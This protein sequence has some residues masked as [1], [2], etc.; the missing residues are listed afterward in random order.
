MK[1]PSH[2]H[3]PMTPGSWVEYQQFDITG[4]RHPDSGMIDI[5]TSTPKVNNRTRFR[6]THVVV[7]YPMVP[8]IAIVD[9][10]EGVVAD[11]NTPIWEKSLFQKLEDKGDGSPAWIGECGSAGGPRDQSTPPAWDVGPSGFY[12][13]A[14]P[15]LAINVTD[16]TVIETF[17][18]KAGLYDWYTGIRTDY[19]P[20]KTVYVHT[21][22]GPGANGVWWWPQYPDQIRTALT[23]YK[24]DGVTI[25]Q[26]YNYLFAR[27]V[28]M[29]N[30]WQ[31]YVDKN[32]RV[33]DGQQWQII[34][35]SP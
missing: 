27:N 23:E 20:A 30:Y 9:S 31:G 28:G 33:Y 7:P 26:A 11:I 19:P 6:R 15:E 1:L 4:Y 12:D 10:A 8:C 5:W 24:P 29:I 14:E 3:W 25:H 32:N 21:G 17:H 2:T 22:R 13:I 34:R 16:G 35:R 18:E